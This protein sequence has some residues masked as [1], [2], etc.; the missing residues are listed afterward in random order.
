M[1]NHDDKLLRQFFSEA[2]QQTMADDGFSSRVM[3]RLPRRMNWFSR[4]WTVCCILVAVALAYATDILDDLRIDYEVWRSTIT[5]D[6][7]ISVSATVMMVVAGLLVVALCEI[8]APSQ[9]SLL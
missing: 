6:D 9:R 8:L 2:S 4:L 7:V 3:H 5:A 1:D